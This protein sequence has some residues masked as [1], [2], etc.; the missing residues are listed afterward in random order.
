MINVDSKDSNLFQCIVTP[1]PSSVPTPAEST[2]VADKGMYSEELKLIQTFDKPHEE[3]LRQKAIYLGK[4]EKKYTLVL[5]LDET[6]VFCASV[7]EKEGR[8]EY[9]LKIR[10]FAKELLES[11]S[12][13]YEIVVFTAG[14]ESYATHVVGLLD[15]E[16]KS[17][18]R[19]IS[20]ESCI[21][22][23]GDYWIK[24]LRIL[25]L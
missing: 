19:A 13:I 23:N 7:V 20:R 24:D 16:R 11:L 6:L 12:E 25:N 18:T 15:P 3:E 14:C 22:R 17:I 1:Q 8:R 4:K 21:R 9:N 10:P 5:D 2:E